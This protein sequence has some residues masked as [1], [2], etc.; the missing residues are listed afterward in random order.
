MLQQADSADASQQKEALRL[1]E[2]ALLYRPYD[3]EINHKAARVALAVGEI[4][5]AKEY[6]ERSLEQRPEVGLYHR[7]LGEV[8][9]KL[10]HHGHAVQEL[11]KALELDGS[12]HE[13]RELLHKLR[14]RGR[15]S[16]GGKR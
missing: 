13:T 10:G 8:H 6:V 16:A 1:Y 7:T 5:K 12:D 3:P 9:R 4:E 14:Q 11:E 2:E 15:A